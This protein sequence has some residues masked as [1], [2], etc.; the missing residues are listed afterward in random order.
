MLEQQL[1][2][3]MPVLENFF[4]NPVGLLALAALVPLLIFYLARPQPEERMMPSIMFFR[5]QEGESKLKN[6]FRTLLRNL[7]LLLHVL[8]ILAFAF[9]LAEPFAEVPERPDDAVIVLDRSAS[10]QSQI[11]DVENFVEDNIG[12][13]NTVIAS[14]ART[15]VIAENVAGE[16][17][18]SILR[19]IEY[20]DTETDIVSGIQTAGNYPGELVVASDLDQTVDSRDPVQALESSSKPIELM[21]SEASNAYAVTDLKVNRNTTEISIR[22][23]LSETETVEADFNGMNQDLELDPGLNIHEV[24]HSS[25]RNTFTLPDDGLNVDNKAFFV[26]PE[27]ESVGVK[28]A[29]TDR[30]FEKAVQLI[31]E[32]RNT[33]LDSNTDVFYLN[34]EAEDPETVREKVDNGASA[35]VTSDSE[36]LKDVFEFDTSAA[37]KGGSVVLNYP[38]RIDIGSVVYVDRGLEDGES[39]STP[40]EAVKIHQYGNGEVLAFNAEMVQFRRNI[41]YP[42][43]WRQIILRMSETQTAGEMNVRTGTSLDTGDST[44]FV[45]NTGFYEENGKTYAANLLSAE[46]SS[47]N[48]HYQEFSGST[49]AVTTE[50]N[51]QNLSVFIIALLLVLELIYLYKI[52]EI[53]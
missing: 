36:A 14:G 38:R 27:S 41:L 44:L 30:Y 20:R 48:S 8:V 2:A 25:G 18:L 32:T 19:N 33:V 31:G 29:R 39:L 34:G 49:A 6:A 23:F 21:K 12:E 26:V 45:S 22:N 5:Q 47:L 7:V 28:T 43:F 50:R 11:N 51:I 13:R 24:R 15:E 40:E 9:T 4:L 37:E 3:L 46:E 53:R 16:Q 35:I 52:G 42:I 17:A 1:Q 10:M